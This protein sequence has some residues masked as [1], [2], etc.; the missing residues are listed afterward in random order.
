MASGFSSNP[1][2]RLRIRMPTAVVNAMP[3]TLQASIPFL[4]SIPTIWE[5]IVANAYRS[6]V[7]QLVLGLSRDQEIGGSNPLA[8]TKFLPMSRVA[9][10]ISNLRSGKVQRALVPGQ[11]VDTSNP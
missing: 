2:S 8:P 7:Q 6:G 5:K 10:R 4:S 9:H 1:F 11:D 3:S